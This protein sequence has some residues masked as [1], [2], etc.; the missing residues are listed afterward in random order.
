MSLR[1]CSILCFVVAM[2]AGSALAHEGHAHKVMGTVSSV[3]DGAL[4]VKSTSGEASHLVLTETTR[5]SRSGA[6]L[7]AAELKPGDRVVVTYEESKG[8]DGK[9]ILTATEVRVGAKR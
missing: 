8:T 5:I 9:P 3:Q 7:K 6:T 4:D 2:A 1:I